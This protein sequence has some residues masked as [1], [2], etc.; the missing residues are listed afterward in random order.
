M[1]FKNP[2]FVLIIILSSVSQL[3][4]AENTVLNHFIEKDKTLERGVYIIENNV[5]IS[6]DATLTVKSGSKL[7][8]RKGASLKVDGGLILEGAPNNLIEITSENI[9]SEGYG[10]IISGIN[11]EKKIVIHFSKFSY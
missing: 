6:K 7:L 1:T 11:R 5:K 8:F 2:F 3:L 4:M 10:I 9:Q